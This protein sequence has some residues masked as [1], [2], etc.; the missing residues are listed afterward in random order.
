MREKKERERKRGKAH[1]QFVLLRSTWPCDRPSVDSHSSGWCTLIEPATTAMSTT[2]CATSDGCVVREREPWPTKVNAQ[3]FIIICP[4]CVWSISA[5]CLVDEERALV[6][7]RKKERE[8]GN[9]PWRKE[10]AKVAE[11]EQRKDPV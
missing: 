6:R 7:K 10:G 3:F 8:E 2:P 11:R 4:V 1:S 9:S 5:L